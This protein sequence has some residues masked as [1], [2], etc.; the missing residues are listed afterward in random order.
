MSKENRLVLGLIFLAYI[1]SYLLHIYWIYWASHYPQFFWHNQLMINNPDGYFYGSGAQK[2]VYHMHTYNP[3]LMHIYHYGTAVLTAY[4]AEFFHISIDTLML[5]LPP[6]IS[7]LVV[8]PIILIG[9]LYKNLTWGFLAA[10]IASIGWSYYNRTLAGYYD[11]DMFSVSL[12]MFIL[13][14]ILASIKNRSLNYLLLA[15]FTVIIYPWLYEQGLSIIYAMGIMAFLYLLIF[16][17][18]DEFTYKFIAIFSLALMDINFG[19]R[20]I[21]VIGL[22]YLFK[23]KKLQIKYLQ[24]LSGVLFLGFFL[25]GNVFGIILHKIFSY[26]TVTD[27]MGGLKFLNVNKTVREA[28]HIPWYIL[29]DRIIGSTLGF[30]VAITGYILLVKRYK[31]FIIALPLWGIGLFAF[32][33]GL[34]FTVYAV[35]IAALSGVYL[36]FWIVE[37]LKIKNK[38]LKVIIPFLGS[39]FL[40]IPNVTHIYGC[41]EKN[42]FLAFFEKIYPLKS[43]P[44]L[45]PTVLNKEEVAVLN[46]L[47]HIS[48]EK[49]YVITWWDYGYP[50]WY[51]ADVNTLI[52]GGKHEQDN[53]IVSKILTTSNQRLAYN[54]GKLAIKAYIENNYTKPAALTLFIK[55]GK[56]IDVNKFLKKISDENFKGVKLDR[57]LYL[58]LPFRMFNIFSTI[59]EFSNRNLNTGKVY[60]PHF[61]YKG[62][63]YKKE[64]YLFVGMFPIDIKNALIKINNALIPLKEI[65]IVGYNKK[66]NLIV[67]KNK[68]RTK[69]LYLIILQDY[70]S[71]LL[72][73]DYYYH[74]TFV[75]MFVFQNYDKKLFE[76]IILNP[77]I[78]I[79]KFK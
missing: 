71:A 20:I 36:F 1:F 68:I 49:D 46:K 50:I 25:T 52:D 7:S 23:E 55:N 34:R 24:I 33:G 38:T 57:N 12:P 21:G 59:S 47:K 2:I 61:Y 4:L 78:K 13:Y 63:I 56:A 37:Q 41:C 15:S 74:S 69:G 64:N 29:F 73:D 30:L 27:K 42:K 14:F 39:I 31:E 18:K 40:I 51:Y 53:F 6:I 28:S 3:R 76:P 11:T 43:Y 5:Y 60:P 19:V 72:M 16:Y 35:P 65:D 26:S 79:Y 22:Y 70:G 66:M 45:V 44:Y 8:I 75:Q 32:I 58:L 48:N 77:L 54:L 10:L 9:K 62:R 17:Y 67:R